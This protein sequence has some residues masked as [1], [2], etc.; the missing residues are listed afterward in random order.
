[1]NQVLN[2]DKNKNTGRPEVVINQY[3][4][5]QTVYPR[6]LIGPGT[7][8]YNETLAYSQTVTASKFLVIAFQKVH[9]LNRELQEYQSDHNI[10]INSI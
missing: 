1:M 8:S 6:K 5:N 9:E 7:N 2:N 3:P 4:E 10:D